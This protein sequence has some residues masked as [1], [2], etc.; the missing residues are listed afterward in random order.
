VRKE[1]MAVVRKYGKGWQVRIRKKNYAPGKM[2]HAALITLRAA[3]TR[4][5]IILN[6]NNHDLTLSWTCS[7][8]F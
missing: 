6:S 7:K 3:G 5:C 2:L 1:Y 4:A 8:T